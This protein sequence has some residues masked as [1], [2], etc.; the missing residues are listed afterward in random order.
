[1]CMNPVCTDLVGTRPEHQSSL[2]VAAWSKHRSMCTHRQC[3]QKF[4]AVCVSSMRSFTEVWLPCQA[5][6]KSCCTVKKASQKAPLA[7]PHKEV[8]PTKH[9]TGSV[10]PGCSQLHVAFQP[11]RFKQCK[12]RPKPNLADCQP[13][14]P[15]S[16]AMCA[17]EW[18]YIVCHVG[19]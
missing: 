14:R 7:T 17:R 4:C 12:S 13:Q 18:S 10:C 15:V 16:M 3:Q 9:L 1:M 8:S 2:S 6:I 11:N 19:R 5:T